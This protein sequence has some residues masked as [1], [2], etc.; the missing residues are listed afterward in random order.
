MSIAEEVVS[1]GFVTSGNSLRISLAGNLSGVT[2]PWCSSPQDNNEDLA[3][4][5]IGY[6]KGQ[7]R[8]LTL[9]ALCSIVVEDN[10]SAFDLENALGRK[11][12]EAKRASLE[13]MPL[14]SL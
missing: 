9:L 2:G 5:C 7:A 3:A 4:Q 11:K 6:S 8:T 10:V 12:V 14:I 13:L 1:D